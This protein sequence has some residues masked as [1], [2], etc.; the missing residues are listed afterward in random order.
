M[1]DEVTIVHAGDIHLDSPLRG[2][3]RLGDRDLAQRLRLATRQALCNLIE[4]TIETRASALVLAGDIYDGD[5]KD[6][7]TG[8]F[9]VEQ[10]A[11]LA[12]AGI[13]VLLAAGNH[14]AASIITKSLTL[15]SN[16][17]AFSTDKAET[18]IHEDIGIAFHGQGFAER[19]V[20]KNLAS[21][22]P[23]PEPGL[24][25]VGVLHTSA[26]GY[27]DHDPYAP[28][29]IDDLKSKGYEYFA[30]G[31][32]HKHEVLCEGRTT[33]AFSGNLQGRHVKETGPKGALWV[34]LRAGKP[35]HLEFEPL[36]VA[37][38]ENLTI[39]VAECEDLE[40]V[41]EVVQESLTAAR[42]AADDRPLVARLTLVGTSRAAGDL[43]DHARVEAEF[44]LLSTRLGVALERIRTQVVP[45]ESRVVL[46]AAQLDNLRELAGREA[47]DGE[48]VQALLQPISARTDAPLRR[49]GLLEDVDHEVLVTTALN[50]LMGRLSRRTP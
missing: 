39:D 27:A 49:L 4:R 11:V 26:A 14:D 23:E 29:S 15:P 16:V 10:M 48:H 45:P 5:W 37:R 41:L 46:P 43:S 8:R 40:D 12:D 21:H 25:N 18:K 38:W 2:L 24:I 13:P 28:C 9:F 32:I 50:D 31:H 1:T 44:D 17:H 7:A 22:Y 20:L 6:Y 42:T 35:A 3:E 30:L 34:T 33:A 36:D 47:F 19:A